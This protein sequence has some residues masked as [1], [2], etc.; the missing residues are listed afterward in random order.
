VT[1]VSMYFNILLRFL[2]C[3]HIENEF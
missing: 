3:N 2:K 1:G